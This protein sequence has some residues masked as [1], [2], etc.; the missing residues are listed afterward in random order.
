[1]RLPRFEYLQPEDLAQALDFAARHGEE[2]K[3][4]AGGTDLLVRMKNRL[5]TPKILMSLKNVD[6][7]SHITESK[8]SVSI[9]AN[10]SLAA[11]IDSQIIRDRFTA[12]AVSAQR[13]HIETR[14]RLFL[15]GR[16]P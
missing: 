10:T 12:L 2:M 13:A 8:G 1:M 14:C 5:L 9:G 3:I 11:V 15:D 6:A 4:L 16:E 7:L